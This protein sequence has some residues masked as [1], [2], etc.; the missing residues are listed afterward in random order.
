MVPLVL[1]VRPLS[2]PDR[3][4]DG[5]HCRDET[6]STIQPTAATAAATIIRVDSASQSRVEAWLDDGAVA[7]GAA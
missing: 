4:Q 6:T 5:P 3:A 1:V 2:S 7:S